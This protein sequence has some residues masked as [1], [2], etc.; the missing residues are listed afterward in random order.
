MLETIYYLKYKIGDFMRS[1]PYGLR[2]LIKWRKTIW[3]DRDYDYYYIYEIL[4]KKLEFVAEHTEKHSMLENSEQHAKDIRECIRLIHALQHEEFETQAAEKCIS[5]SLYDN[6][7]NE[8]FKQVFEEAQKKTD[9]AKSKLFDTL[10]N[11]IEHW[12]D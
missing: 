3:N 12:W 2:N 11:K 10:K 7:S 8:E 5:T 1:V 6:M 4:K 9:E